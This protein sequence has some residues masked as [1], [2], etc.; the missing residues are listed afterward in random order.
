MALALAMAPAASAAPDDV[1]FE[2]ETMTLP[3]AD[4]GATVADPNASG[5]QAKAIWS[6]RTAST[7]TTTTRSSV[8]LF[9]RARG[10]EC[11]GAPTISVKVDGY[12]WYAGPVATSAYNELGV[13]VSIPAGDHSVTVSFT[14]NASWV[15]NGVTVCDR[16]VWID[17]VTLVATPFRADGWRNQPLSD[18]APIKAN[19]DVLRDELRDQVQDSLDYP[20]SPQNAGTWVNTTQYSPPVY[21]VPPGQPTVRVD[22]PKDRPSLQ[23]QW[24]HVPLPPDAQPAQGTDSELTVWQPSTDTIW[25]FWHM[26]KDPAGNWSAEYG[27]RMP[28][29]SLHQGNFEDPPLGP[30]RK[31]G[32]TATSIALL[33][34]LQRIEEIRRGVID[35]AVDFAVTTPRGR[36]GWCWPAQRTDSKL[37]SRA[38]EAI[39]AGTR[40]RLPASLDID[41]LSLTP[42]A[43]IL[44]KAIQRYGMV[45]RDSGGLVVFF[46]ENPTPLGPDKNPY[47]VFFGGRYPNARPGGALENFP[48]DRLQVVEQPPGTGCED[49]PD[50][51]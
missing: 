39:P 40:F 1:T 43:K 48:W 41:S 13:R 6:N 34:G 11:V 38:P 12:E 4:D 35:H 50:P 21:V 3:A 46:A 20:T 33:A 17:R 23:A 32:A 51:D 47:S 28:N 44:A 42:Y 49:D 18:T 14:N 25:D 2:G 19:S 22:D 31:L 30:G 36:D 10:T 24:D 29:V 37:T 26:T 7:T 15:V 45:A 9:V 5:G 27:G 8:H 16:N